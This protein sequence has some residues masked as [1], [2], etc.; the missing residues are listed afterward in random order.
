MRNASSLVLLENNW[1]FYWIVSNGKAKSYFTISSWNLPSTTQ[2]HNLSLDKNQEAHEL[3]VAWSRVLRRVMSLLP[4]W[5]TVLAPA[6]ELGSCQ[7]VHLTSTEERKVCVS[8]I[9]QIC[10]N[11]IF[12]SWDIPFCDD[13][14]SIKWKISNLFPYETETWKIIW[15]GGSLT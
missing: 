1:C 8:A 13:K 15:K 10:L 4:I 7:G 12:T 11:K 2:C 3:C 9:A 14:L 5:I 6:A